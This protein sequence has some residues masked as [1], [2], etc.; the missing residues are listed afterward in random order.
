MNTTSTRRAFVA[1]GTLT[2]L[3]FSSSSRAVDKHTLALAK[4]AATYTQEMKACLSIADATQCYALADQKD[5]DCRRAAGS[6]GHSKITPPE[7]LLTIEG[8][9]QQLK[10][11]P[12]GA[13]KKK[14]LSCGGPFSRICAEGHARAPTCELSSS[15]RAQSSQGISVPPPQVVVDLNTTKDGCSNGTLLLCPTGF[16]QAAHVGVDLCWDS[17]SNIP[18]YE[19]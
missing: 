17:T 1:L 19:Y 18:R 10:T 3:C 12:M 8:H 5:L 14:P 2:A 9:Q 7:L 13:V 11:N 6:A 15:E 4:C 16:T